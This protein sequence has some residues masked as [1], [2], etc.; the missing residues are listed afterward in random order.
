MPLDDLDAVAEQPGDFLDGERRD[1]LSQFTA[2]V[3]RSR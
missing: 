2:A 3:W 1:A